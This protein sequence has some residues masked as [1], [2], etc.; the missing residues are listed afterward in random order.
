MGNKSKTKSFSLG[1]VTKIIIFVVATLFAV[2]AILT[3][4]SVRNAANTINDNISQH[5]LDQTIAYG[6]YLEEKVSSN[7]G[8]LTYDEYNKILAKVKVSGYASSYAYIVDKEGTMM[9]HPTFEK[10]G[11]PVTNE[12]VKGLVEGL[13]KGK[14][15]APECVTYFFK[16]AWKYAAYDILSDDSI[17]VITMDQSELDGSINSFRNQSLLGG[18]VVGVILVIISVFVSLIIVRPFKLIL[19]CTNKIAQ[20]DLT[21]DPVARKLSTRTDEV[22]KIAV[23]VMNVQ[24]A[25]IDIITTINE[26][27]AT[28]HDSAQSVRD[29]ASVISEQSSDNSAT[30]EQLAAS[31]Q[32]T[33]ATTETIDANITH[34]KQKIDDITGLTGDGS[35][36]AQEIMNRAVSLKAS[37]S[38]AIDRTQKMLDNVKDQTNAAIAKSKAVEKIQELTAAIKAIAAQTG[39][40]SLNASIE[41]ARAGEQGRGFAVVAGEIGNLAS[42]STEAVNNITSIVSEVQQAVVNMTECLNTT[43][44]FLEETVANDYQDFSEVGVR[45]SEDASSFDKSMSTI[46][47]S[48]IELS[49]AIKDIV[50]AVNGINTTISE[51]TAGISDISEKTNDMVSSTSRTNSMIEENLEDAVRLR[52]LVSK[53]KI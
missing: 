11:K 37:S 12:V 53:F 21:D 25:F 6:S 36:L 32:E 4:I 22:G 5:I 3:I 18:T 20:L 43:L 15:P 23:A 14:R 27:A 26:I 41:A 50:V 31:M 28:L 33:S 52:E 17:L 48:S 42:Q 39:L 35:R 8:A 46:S 10:V 45:Y 44:K 19:Q 1:L 2:S 30:T 9:Y 24:A 47:T 16:D 38:Q 34:I 51:A 7:G 13:A 29:I 49:E 40:L